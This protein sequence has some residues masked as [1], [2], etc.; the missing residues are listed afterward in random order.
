MITPV[1]RPTHRPIVILIR[2]GWGS[3]PHAEWD[4]ANAVHLARKPVDD[5][6]MADYPYVLIRTCGVDVGL[7]D[8]VMGNSEVGHQNIGAGRIVEQEIMRITGRINDGTFFS[9]RTLVGA[10]ENAA[11]SG[12]RVHVL[13]LCSD[14]RVHSDLDHLYGLLELSRR[15]RFP[16]DRVAVHAF[17][18]GRDTSPHRGVN[19]IQAVED[20]CREAGVSP[21]AS[22]IGR[23]YAMDRDNRWDRIETAYRMLIAGE[24]RRFASA[25]EAVRHYYANPSE[26]ARSGDEFVLP[27]L[28]VRGEDGPTTIRDGDSVILFNYR[29]DRPRQ[30]TKAFVYDAFPYRDTG[31]EQTIHGFDR[32]KKLDLYF[33]TMTAY[34]EGLPVHVAFDKPPKMEHIL[35]AYISDCGLRQFRCAE[36]EKYAHVTYFFNDYRDEHFPGEERQ[37]VPSQRDISTYDQKPEMSAYEVTESM[38][39][40]IAMG[41]DDLIVVNY[42]NGDMVGH[43]GNLQ[44]AIR[45]VEAVDECVGKVAEAALARGGGLIVTA[46]HGNCEQMIDPATG[47]PHTA[48]TSYDVQLIVVDE[49]FRGRR[50]R[51]GGR[52]ADIAPTA[53]DMLGL[54]KPGAMTGTSLLQ[55]L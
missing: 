54:P 23:Y 32:G 45:A 8:G 41:I 24:G 52:L 43:T 50:L 55:A 5:R 29:G 18:D 25:V 35:G 38:I 16:G 37:I 19:F 42:A 33:A 11:R 21:V 36:T 10:F 26:P 51:I 31:S 28:I 53:L 3:N 20:K 2:D 27:S 4:H 6:L 22:V 49:R 48:H 30:L 34:E 40:R 1:N 15:M 14:G 46:D 44:A 13:G 7:P 17:T 47:G 39:Q 9:N 12:G